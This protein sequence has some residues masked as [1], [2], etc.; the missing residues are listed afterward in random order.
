M[1][2]KY[3]A[4][5]YKEKELL[6]EGRHQLSI[7][8]NAMTFQNLKQAERVVKFDN[9]TVIKCKS[10]FGQDIIN[11]HVPKKI[12]EKFPVREFI[13]IEGRNF[14]F[15]HYEADGIHRCI[16]WDV[17]KN[18]AAEFKGITFPCNYANAKL[19][20]LS[21]EVS[22]VDSEDIEWEG[23]YPSQIDCD[24]VT[25]DC[26]HD[27]YYIEPTE[28]TNNCSQ[29]YAT[30]SLPGYTDSVTESRRCYC[31]YDPLM[32]C[33]T[34][35]YH[36][37]EGER[38]KNIH[39]YNLNPGYKAIYEGFTGYVYTERISH[40]VELS[41]GLYNDQWAYYQNLLTY[42][43]DKTET[44]KIF[45]PIK[46]DPL[47]ILTPETYHHSISDELQV[48]IPFE[49]TWTYECQRRKF[50]YNC[51]IQLFS[52]VSDKMVVNIFSSQHI[53]EEQYTE[54]DEGTPPP[55][56]TG[57]CV[58]PENLPIDYLELRTIDIAASIDY[59]SAGIKEVDP[60]N[61]VLNNDFGDLVKLLIEDYHIQ[62]GTADIAIA[63]VP[64]EVEIYQEAL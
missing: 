5:S 17:E 64:L 55:P 12:E 59:F 2:I 49:Y 15:V 42:D 43:L 44:H 28:K 37:T 22:L 24:A 36:Y 45:V 23:M 7:L 58:N 60:F 27:C 62:V 18:A 30:P 8:K 53:P 48:W 35:C 10:C 16:V 32:C 3:Q 6:G 19:Y 61:Q 47:T 50:Q 11:I 54:K 29:S 41:T 39:W 38:I 31:I 52:T 33:S 56:H 63:D 9:G 40:E 51:K 57:G 13:L 25:P 46:E 21:L 4:N 14:V 1:T 34:P 20:I 26:D